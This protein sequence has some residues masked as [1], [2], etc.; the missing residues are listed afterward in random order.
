MESGTMC[1][2]MD[3]LEGSHRWQE[4]EV[5]TTCT[6]KSIVT[7]REKDGTPDLTRIGQVMAAMRRLGTAKKY[8]GNPVKWV[9]P[10]QF[11]GHMNRRWAKPV[12]G[13]EYMGFAL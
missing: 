11:A 5:M 8:D 6:I 12:P 3:R 9:R 2:Y 13:T 7:N 1:K 10:D 4:Y